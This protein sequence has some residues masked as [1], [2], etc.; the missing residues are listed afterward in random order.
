MEGG[1][2]PADPHL[3]PQGREQAQR[4]AVWLAD[5]TV[6]HLVT[7]PLVRARETGARVAEAVGLAPEV[8]EGV[9]EW[10]AGSHEYIP[11]EELRLLQDERWFAMIEGRWEDNGGVDPV[12]Y[13]NQVVDAIER[14]I[15]RF[16]AGRVVV[17]CHGGAINAYLGHVVGIERPLWFE[18]AYASISR[19]AA[20]RT[21][22][23]SIVSVNETAHLRSSAAPR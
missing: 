2:G 18:P 9:A 5:E 1:D 17:V 3:T 19:V 22:V 16:P 4:L 8:V 14:V 10:D 7:S 12:A 20:S 11:V 21:G 23:R 15:A 13:R 6:D